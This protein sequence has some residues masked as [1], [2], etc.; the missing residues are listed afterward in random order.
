[1]AIESVWMRC[2]KCGTVRQ[3][4]P[5]STRCGA[6]SVASDCLPCGG[7]LERCDA[8]TETTLGSREWLEAKAMAAAFS[9]E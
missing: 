6:R 7:K 3:R 4:Y 1:M 9:R 8:P 2:Q 5:Q